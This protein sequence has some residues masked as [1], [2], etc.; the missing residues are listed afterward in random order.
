MPAKRPKKRTQAKKAPAKKL[1]IHA[2]Y[3]AQPFVQFFAIISVFFVFTHC[4]PLAS[5]TDKKG[6]SLATTTITEKSS[7]VVAA[8]TQEDAI[9]KSLQDISLSDIEIL[10]K[11]EFQN[12]AP[13]SLKE[14]FTKNQI[15][16]AFERR[17]NHLANNR[18]PKTFYFPL[19]D[20]QA[21]ELVEQGSIRLDLGEQLH[22]KI[23]DKARDA[24]YANLQDAEDLGA[25]VYLVWPNNTVHQE[26]P[27]IP[28]RVALGMPYDNAA[29]MELSLQENPA[30]SV[31]N[32]ML[33]KAALADAGQLAVVL[34]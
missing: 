29:Y 21:A 10:S 2:F 8:L 20:K 25:T 1:L 24:F 26:I 17:Q 28:V 5:S 12:L 14:K 6:S 30:D 11:N 32:A 3:L 16:K 4:S 27:A 22:N 23:N 33:L 31:S 13:L 9:Q 19:N 7:E 18:I 34:E 15:D